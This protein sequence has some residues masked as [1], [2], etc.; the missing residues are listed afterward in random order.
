[1]KN[2]T[3]HTVAVFSLVGLLVA[4]DPASQPPSAG[5]TQQTATKESVETED[6]GTREVVMSGIPTWPPLAEQEDL[7][8][9]AENQFTTNI[10]MV[11]DTSGSMDNPCTVE[12]ETVDNKFTS[13]VN[14]ALDFIE[15]APVD[16][17]IGV[18][19]FGGDAAREVSPLSNDKSVAVDAIKSL[20]S[21]G[22]TPMAHAIEI[23]NHS[24]ENQGRLQQ[25]NGYYRLVLLGDGDPAD[26]VKTV[27]WLDH[28]VWHTAV[29]LHTIGFCADLR[30]LERPGMIYKNVNNAQELTKAFASVL[31]EVD[32]TDSADIDGGTW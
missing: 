7:V 1:M 8:V 11:I 4:C 12:G 24:L 16:T 23:A 22:G 2:I 15:K 10:I 26:A 19:E 3:K 21:G 14:A 25:G 27:S 30:V 29:S 18:V 28:M 6:A 5:N 20:R 32:L 13:A 31:A 9:F 17:N